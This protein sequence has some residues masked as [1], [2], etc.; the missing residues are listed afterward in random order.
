MLTKDELERDNARLQRKIERL[1]AAPPK[2]VE[3]VV[4]K[5]VEKIVEVPAPLKVSVTEQRSIQSHPIL[6]ITSETVVTENS[7]G[8]GRIGDGATIVRT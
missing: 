6:G 7:I 4:E 8:D 3:K 5:L 2:V 1:E